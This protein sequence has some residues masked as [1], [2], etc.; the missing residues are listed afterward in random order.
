MR[1]RVTVHA[2]RSHFVI[3]ALLVAGSHR[4]RAVAGA[5]RSN[6]RRRPGGTG[7][8]DAMGRHRY[9]ADEMFAPGKKREV[10]VVAWYPAARQRRHSRA[11]HARRHGRGPELRAARA[12]GDAFD[13]LATVKTHA[14]LDAA[15]AA[16][17]GALSGDRVSAR[18]HRP[19]ELAHRADRRSGQSTAR[20][21]SASSIRTKRPARC[22]PTARWSPSSTRRARCARASWTCSTSG[23]PK[24]GRW[25]RS[26]RRRTMPRKRS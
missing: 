13:G 11:L 6:C 5:R 19:A 12:A 8:H 17:P 1:A 4:L 18:L 22:S 23:D 16:T 3:R 15:P 10:E 20:P 24:A 2:R 21:S 7:R 25:R 26:P 9:L 14:T